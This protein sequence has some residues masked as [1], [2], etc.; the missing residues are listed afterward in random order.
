MCQLIKHTEFQSSMTRVYPLEIV[1]AG[2]EQLPGEH[3]CSEQQV[4]DEY[5]D[6]LPILKHGDVV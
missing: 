5:K 2:G 3:E 4:F 1:C 6:V